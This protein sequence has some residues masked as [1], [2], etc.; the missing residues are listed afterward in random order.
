[1]D[2]KKFRELKIILLGLPLPVL[3]IVTLLLYS[4]KAKSKAYDPTDEKVTISNIEIPTPAIKNRV[5]QNQLD[6]FFQAESNQNES[7]YIESYNFANNPTDNNE[8][9]ALDSKIE[10]IE[11]NTFDSY[12]PNTGTQIHN[13]LAYESTT[14]STQ[15][16]ETH[17]A[18]EDNILSVKEKAIEIEIEKSR[19][20]RN[21]RLASAGV[22]V[23]YNIPT[24]QN[25]EQISDK[26]DQKD[27]SKETPSTEVIV[28]EKGKRNRKGD[29]FFT[30]T[31]SSAS[32]NLL[33]A[34]IHGDQEIVN[35]SVVKLRVLQS[36]SLSNGV[37]VPAN[38]YIYGIANINQDRVNISIN[39]IA[40]NNNSYQLKRE[41]CD[42]TGISGIFIPSLANTQDINN[43]G[44]DV[45]DEL[46]QIGRAT[47]VAGRVAGSVIQS[48]KNIIRK[49]ANEKKVLLKSNHKIYLK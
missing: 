28:T 9:V 11:N 40:I 10:T 19:A 17:E 12:T 25:E 44:L 13:E 29:A 45:V 34:V 21:K 5:A 1:M 15:V 2:K 49:S 48:G 36:F 6:A 20:A 30:T 35:G 7:E 14:K 42:N 3:L 46:T 23:G 33:P 18:K 43:A 26:D 41:V 4:V 8:A 37:Q 38:H 39:N 32:G 27:N 47:G 22:P 16:K 31:S 24:T